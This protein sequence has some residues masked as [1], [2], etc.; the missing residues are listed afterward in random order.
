MKFLRERGIAI[1]GYAETR[2][3][4]KSGKSAIQLGGEALQSLLDKTG[5]DRRRIDGFALTLSLAEAGNPMWSN[6][7]AEALGLSPSWMQAT[8]LGGATAVG[9]VARAAAAIHAGLCEVV[10]CLCA[11]APSTSNTSRQSGYRPE[12]MDPQGYYGPPVVFGLLSSAYH[13]RH[14]LPERGLAKLAVAQ[15]NG[16]LANPN[17]C[18]T[19]RVPLTEQDYLDSRRI[20]DPVR[21]LDC[22]MP[23]DGASAL[24]IASTKAAKELGAKTLVHPLAF[25]ETTNFDAL[26]TIDDI[27]QSGFTVSGPRALADA[28]MKPSD[29]RMFHPYDDFLIAVMLQLEQVGFC[30]AGGSGEFVLGRDIGPRGQLPINTGGGMISSGQPGLAGGGVVLTEAVRQMFGEAEGRQVP[31]AST[32]MVTGI[33]SMHYARNW[34]TSSVLILE[35]G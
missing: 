8:D 34:G 21:L 2:L 4:R 5:M 19:L 9:N 32:A 17:A 25:R 29:I 27:T 13:E 16:A 31:D 12:F 15:R 26:Q 10:L 23:V 24:L 20:S 3:E 14:G 1:C 7:V 18:D 35:R 11:D 22:V 33:G 6:V 30:A 28:G